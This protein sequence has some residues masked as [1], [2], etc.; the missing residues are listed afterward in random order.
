MSD[1]D[2]PRTERVSHTIHDWIDFIHL[3]KIYIITAL[4]PTLEV[5]T[6]ILPLEVGLKVVQSLE[7]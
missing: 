4:C 5:Q 2:G 6:N 7:M 3:I 1:R